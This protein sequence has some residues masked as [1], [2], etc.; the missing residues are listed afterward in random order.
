MTEAAALFGAWL[1][2]LAAV[3]LPQ[4]WIGSRLLRVALAWP[5]GIAIV[6]L[7]TLM[8][9][10]LVPGSALAQLLLEA[11]V[12][13]GLLL[14]RRWMRTDAAP[15]ADDGRRGL[16]VAAGYGGLTALV[17]AVLLLTVTGVAQ[18]GG[19]MPFGSHDA[20]IFWNLKARYIAEG[21]ANWTTLWSRPEHVH[22]GYPLLMPLNV[23]RLW[24][25]AGASTTDGPLFFA[26]ANAGALALLLFA[27]LRRFAGAW[28]GL[29]GLG[30]LVATPYLATHAAAQ[31]ADVLLGLTFL[32]AAV[33]CALMMRSPTIPNALLAGALGGALLFT[34]NEGLVAAAPLAAVTLLV[35]VRAHG[36]RRA[37]GLAAA[38]VAGAL[39]LTLATFYVKLV[40]AGPDASGN[41]IQ[42]WAK[43]ID[44]GWHL[45]VLRFTGWMLENLPN[46]YVLVAALAYVVACGFTR[47]RGL[48]GIAVA[49]LAIVAVQ[50]LVYHHVFVLAD[51][52]LTTSGARLFIGLWPTA[53]FAVLVGTRDPGWR[54]SVA[55]TPP[56]RCAPG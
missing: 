16:L 27:G 29:V 4:L 30:T 42:S 2:G 26:S 43:L 17:L 25:Y 38:A 22:P 3:S 37:A 56:L 45:H 40:L 23:A 54:G 15:R 35:C 19:A 18:R 31:Y 1:I 11:D 28:A 52:R 44:L 41:S 33:G 21:G 12:L 9:A 20:T 14:L 34:K 36:R 5:A 48:R 7:T 13:L 49:M 55:A 47:D 8:S 10:L 46:R 32:A 50:W 6:S 39:P 24:I 51:V 53:I